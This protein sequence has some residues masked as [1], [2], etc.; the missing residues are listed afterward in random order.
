MPDQIT[1]TVTTGYGSRII[2]S[3]KGIVVGLILFIGSFGLLF[4]NEGRVDISDIAKTAVDISS[5]SVSTDTAL[6]GKLVSTTGEVNSDQLIGDDMFLVPGKYVAVNRRVEMYAW[7]EESKST[8]K[9]NTGG[10]ETTETTYTYSKKWQENPRSSADFNLTEGHENPVKTMQSVTNKVSTAT[11]GAYSI[12]PQTIALPGFTQIS[13]NADNVTL[14]EGAVLA[15]EQFIFIPTVA[16]GSFVNPQVGDLRVTYNVL[17]PGFTGTVFGK[18]S[19]DR[20]D[21]FVDKDGNRLYRLFTGSREEGVATLHS[22]Y[23]MWLW[24]LRLV[25]FLMMWLGLS[26]LFGPISVILD[27]LPIFGTISRSLIG[28]VTFV[29][30]LVL[31]I[32]TILISMILHS[33]LAVLITVAVVIGGLFYYV[34]HWKKRSTSV[35]APVQPLVPPTPQPPAE[36]PIQ[37]PM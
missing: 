18:L 2:N 22:E 26:A 31:S 12:D 30:A 6:S 25:G 35:Q 16:G 4:W 1:R 21:S 17:L 3:I 32:V 36:P 29:V 28:V 34:K 14:N 15:N 19:G 37:P 24:I 20:I 23:T 27:F 9:T 33:L 5:T 10:S 13:L 8:T 7:E 11:I